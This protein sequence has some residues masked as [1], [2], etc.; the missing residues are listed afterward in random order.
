MT[1]VVEQPVSSLPRMIAVALALGGTG[2]GVFLLLAFGPTVLYPVPFG[3]GYMVTAGYILRV[4]TTPA[5]GLRWLIWS[6]SVLVQGAWLCL[7]IADLGRAGPNLLFW[8]W[9]FA[10]VSSVVALATERSGP[11]VESFAAA[12]GGGR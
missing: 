10:T 2:W 4:A 1:E 7:G 9:A 6:A 3:V 8:W 12:D 5:I 11:E